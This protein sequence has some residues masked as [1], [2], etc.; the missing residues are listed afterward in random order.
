VERAPHGL[1]QPSPL[2]LEPAL[3]VRCPGD[4]HA[5]EQVSPPQRAR[6]VVAALARETLEFDHVGLHRAVAQ[7]QILL[8]RRSDHLRAERLVDQGN[9]L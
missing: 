8:R 7:R 1:E 5:L 2:R 3:E 6:V 9:R 4:P